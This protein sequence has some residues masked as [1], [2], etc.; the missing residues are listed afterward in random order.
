PDSLLALSLPP[1]WVSFQIEA[2][3]AAT[4]PTMATARVRFVVPS[5]LTPAIKVGDRD[6]SPKMPAR[7]A[8][9]TGLAAPRPATSTPGAGPPSPAAG[10]QGMLEATLCVPVDRGTRGWL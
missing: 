1:G 2:V 7:S 6:A 10:P 4:P 3:H 5:D 9:L 8:T